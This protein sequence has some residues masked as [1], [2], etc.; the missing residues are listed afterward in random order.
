MGH[1]ISCKA[2][3]LVVN[4]FK[5]GLD[6]E[7]IKEVQEKESSAVEN[8]K[9]LCGSLARTWQGNGLRDVFLYIG[10]GGRKKKIK[11]KSWWE[12]RG[13]QSRQRDHSMGGRGTW[14]QVLDLALA[15][16]AA[17]PWPQP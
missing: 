4:L 6:E 9:L 12:S 8:F 5:M 13:R 10:K 1:L 2:N 14:N 7:V 11:I 17:S 16:R 3:S 15:K